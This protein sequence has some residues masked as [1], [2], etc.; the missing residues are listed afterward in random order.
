MTVMTDSKTDHSVA[1][2]LKSLG[3]EP[4][5]PGAFDGAWIPTHGERLRVSDGGAAIACEVWLK[6]PV[7]AHCETGACA[8]A[9]RE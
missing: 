3:I 9:V 2:L 4:E 5:N 8:G 6:L 7:T 1:S